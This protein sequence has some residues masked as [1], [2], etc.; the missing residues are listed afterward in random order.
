LPNH[1][2]LTSLVPRP[3]RTPAGL[4]AAA[5]LALSAAGCTFSGTGLEVVPGPGDDAAPGDD[6]PAADAPG[7]ADYAVDRPYDV[8]VDRGPPDLG[9]DAAMPLPTGFPCTAGGMPCASGFCVDGVCCENACAGAC[10]ACSAAKTGGANGRCRPMPVGTDP[11]NECPDEGMTSCKRNGSCDG[12]GA[13]DLYPRGSPCGE[14]S[15]AASQLT[16]HACDGKGVCQPGAP[17]PC[18]GGFIC[19]STLACKTRCMADIDCAAGAGCDLAAGTCSGMKIA[20][21]QACTANAECGTGICAD[22]VCCDKVCTGRCRAC[23]K[24]VTGVEDGTCANIMAG[25]KPTR[26]TECPVQQATCGNNGLCNGAGECQQFADGTQCGT[27]CCGGQG[28]GGNF[29][30]L[31]CQ[32]G[33]CTNQSGM[34]AG[35]CDDG[36]PCSRD[37]CEMVN[38]AH[39]CTHDGACSGTSSC[40]CVA[41]FGGGAFCSDPTGCTAGLNG[42]CMP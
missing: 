23:L 33:A 5:W 35:T 40:C 11:D 17:Q 27:Y 25:V 42:M 12:K 15:C 41:G 34:N 29:C 6:A 32:A 2:R 16:P 21:G 1:C 26:Q 4:C 38:G 10:Q 24:S 19:A 18:P 39:L 7:G 8:A 30:H 13:C 36:S 28:G 22:G 14:S 37:R 9:P 3:S 31:L 20:Q